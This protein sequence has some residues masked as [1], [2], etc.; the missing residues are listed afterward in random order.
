M[1]IGTHI[2]TLTIKMPTPCFLFH[3][4]SSDVKTVIDYLHPLQ[5]DSVR[6]LA[7][8]LGIH[9]ETLNDWN[10]SNARAFLEQVVEAWVRGQDGVEVATWKRL[11]EGLRDE[12]VGHIG[13]AN[14]IEN[15][16]L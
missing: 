14:M 3:S 6:Q 11:V 4:D 16:Q 13:I 9:T 12:T 7:L 1:N 5:K 10:T 8:V 15:E 2:H